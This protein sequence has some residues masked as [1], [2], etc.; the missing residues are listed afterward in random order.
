MGAYCSHHAA[1]ACAA[2]EPKPK[3]R[4]RPFLLLMPAA[5]PKPVVELEERVCA[6]EACGKPF[7]V[8]ANMPKKYCNSKCRNAAC[9]ARMLASAA[10]HV[11]QEVSENR[12]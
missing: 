1:M 10:T 5:K 11:S 12:S 7:M 4:A 8:P 3:H 6:Y 2:N 9:R